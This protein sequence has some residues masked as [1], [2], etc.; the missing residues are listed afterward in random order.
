MQSIISATVL[1][2]IVT[3]TGTAAAQM[4]NP[5]ARARCP[6]N[7]GCVVVEGR[8]ACACVSGHAPDASGNCVPQAAAPQE[9]SREEERQLLRRGRPGFGLYI[10]G[11]VIE[12]IGLGVEIA[13][14]ALL[15]A[16]PYQQCDEDGFCGSPDIR[17]GHGSGG[18]STIPPL[19]S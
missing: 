14:L 1:S 7:A 18:L 16:S 15:I 17:V 13:G 5:C 8:A 12:S 19:Q 9:F 3:V 11:I 6:E 10:T 4:G 2:L